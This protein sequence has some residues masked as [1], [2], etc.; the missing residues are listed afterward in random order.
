MRPLKIWS[1]ILPLC[2]N[3]ALAA[4]S[5][6]LQ[7]PAGNV[8]RVGRAR[9]PGVRKSQAAQAADQRITVGGFQFRIVRVAF[10]KTAMGFVPEGIGPKELLMFVECELLSGRRDDFKALSVLLDRGSG[11]RSKAAALFSGGMMKALTALAVKSASYDYR[12][13]KSNV[14]WAF[15]VHEAEKD[16][17]LIFPTGPVVDLTP[18]IEDR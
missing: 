16:L 18:W 9:E 2:L 12:P 6:A 8:I 3:C 7:G 4:S 11:R 17:A 14:T 10:D 15:V 13:A 5:G 1:I